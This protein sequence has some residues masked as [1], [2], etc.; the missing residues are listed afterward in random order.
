MRCSATSWIRTAGSGRMCKALRQV[1]LD[2]G[3]LGRGMLPLVQLA[4]M[5]WLN[6]LREVSPVYG[7]QGPSAMMHEQGYKGA[8]FSGDSTCKRSF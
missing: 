4:S 5:L 3:V 8:A 6:E 2:G 1:S 7:H